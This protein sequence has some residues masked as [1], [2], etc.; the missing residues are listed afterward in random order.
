M[1]DAR[2][3][4]RWRKRGSAPRV[5]PRPLLP[6]QI[7]KRRS[8][9]V[10]SSY[11]LVSCPLICS[12]PGCPRRDPCNL[13]RGLLT[14]SSW[15]ARAPAR[16][17]FDGREGIA[18]QRTGCGSTNIV[19]S[20]REPRTDPQRTGIGDPT[21]CGRSQRDYSHHSDESRC[22]CTRMDRCGTNAAPVMAEICGRRRAARRLARR[23]RRIASS[24]LRFSTKAGWIANRIGNR[25]LSSVDMG[26]LVFVCPITLCDWVWTIVE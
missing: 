17:R 7:N 12:W 26:T 19:R 6:D 16:R 25:E 22:Q 11:S 4:S 10:R 9:F 5:G 1:R 14:I 8:L 15:D 21:N 23:C 20:W 18:V 24:G 3:S 2:R 13:R